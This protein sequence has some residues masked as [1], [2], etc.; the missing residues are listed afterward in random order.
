MPTP[1]LEECDQ[2]RVILIIFKDGQWIN[3]I[4]HDSRRLYP[5]VF[6]CKHEASAVAESIVQAARKMF[7]A[8]K[9]TA[10]DLDEAASV[11]LKY[12]ETDIIESLGMQGAP[13][14]IRH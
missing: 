13:N 3:A 8:G 9:V 11:S 10:A 1:E 2:K 7:E 4:A 14:I 12:I 5:I 6:P